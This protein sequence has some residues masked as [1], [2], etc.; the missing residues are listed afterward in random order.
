[1]AIDHL[2]R[3]RGTAQLFYHY[4]P[5]NPLNILHRGD[6]RYQ[7]FRKWPGGKNYCI[8]IRNIRSWV[9]IEQ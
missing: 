6:I 4:S 3:R 7:Q 2:L 9:F 8:I 5:G 1:M